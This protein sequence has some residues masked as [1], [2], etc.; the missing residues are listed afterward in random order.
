MAGV[1]EVHVPDLHEGARRLAEDSA[2]VAGAGD[3]GSAAASDAAGSVS[4]GP[5]AAASHRLAASIT[6]AGGGVSTA[7]DA[8]GTTLTSNAERYR[9]DDAEAAAQLRAVDFGAGPW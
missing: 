8:A 5:L 2:E 7:L 3:D 4:G 9:S 6:A 1:Y